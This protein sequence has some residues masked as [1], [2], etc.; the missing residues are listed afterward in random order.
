MQFGHGLF[1]ACPK[2]KKKSSCM[3]TRLPQTR[4]SSIFCIEA[5]GEAMRWTLWK[6]APA[7]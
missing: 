7:V 1:A 2:L 3:G 4:F 5:C 6:T